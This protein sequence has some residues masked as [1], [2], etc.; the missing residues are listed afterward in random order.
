MTAFH[1]INPLLIISTVLIVTLGSCVDT[2]KATYLNG[3]NENSKTAS[4]PIP[5]TI[6][7]KNDLLSITITD[8]NP[9]ASAMFN[10]MT[11]SVGAANPAGNNNN[12]ALGATS[13]NSSEY[14]VNTKGTIQLPLIG[15][16]QASG[17]T[18][19]QLKDNIT[20]KVK[21]Q[22]LLV[23]PVVSIR[24]LNFRVTVLGEVKNPT[25]ISVPNEKITLLEA[26]GMAGDLTI[27]AKRDNVLLIRE[28]NGEKKI[29]RLN[30]NSDELLTSD[31]YYL[32][33]N[34]VVYVEPNKVRVAT[35]GRSQQWLP[36]ILGV[37]TLGV[38]VLDRAL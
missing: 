29:K 4:T 24:F 2:R 28:I 27:Y 12:A 10:R 8:L 5:E 26:I 30:L 1:K 20:K 16:V 33:S 18:K 14:L 25:V 32:R 37:M 35:S 38:I 13:N 3:V 34:D 15:E 21:D 9:D 6:I 19:E 17:L 11:A 22:K 31:Y 23:D 7:D 36:V